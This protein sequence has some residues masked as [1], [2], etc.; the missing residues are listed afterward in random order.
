MGSTLQQVTIRQRPCYIISL[1]LAAMQLPHDDKGMHIYP[2]FRHRRTVAI[3]QE[4][5]S[6]C[7]FPTIQFS[8]VTSEH[9]SCC[10]QQLDSPIS[11]FP[12]P[13]C[14]SQT[15]LTGINNQPKY[16]CTHIHWKHQER[17]SPVLTRRTTDLFSPPKKLSNAQA[18]KRK[19][20]KVLF[21][22][23]P[24]KSNAPNAAAALRLEYWLLRRGYFCGIRSKPASNKSH[25][26]YVNSSKQ[27]LYSC[28]VCGIIFVLNK[29]GQK[30]CL[31]FMRIIKREN[32][33]ADQV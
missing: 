23:F 18:A 4:S 17:P 8:Q 31:Q 15:H 13:P 19:N 29:T 26:W 24:L 5:L 33:I 6:I 25:A 22:F 11:F 14:F 12:L 20:K 10:L 16:Y 9:R 2:L 21:A 27:K 7:Y 3:K 30:I 32:N 28:S 1:Y